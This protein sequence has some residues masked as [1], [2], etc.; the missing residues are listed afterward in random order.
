VPSNACANA[1]PAVVVMVASSANAAVTMR[2]I[3]M[4]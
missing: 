2:E 3:D 4:P 1:V